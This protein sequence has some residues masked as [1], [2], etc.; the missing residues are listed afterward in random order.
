MNNDDEMKAR[1]IRPQHNR[2]L[3]P[4]PI[5]WPILRMGSVPKDRWKYRYR[6][7][8]LWKGKMER[9]NGK[10]KKNRKNGKNRVQ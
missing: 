7:Y 2:A 4:L 9:E 8:G 6:G 1:T 3:F 5:P 10:G